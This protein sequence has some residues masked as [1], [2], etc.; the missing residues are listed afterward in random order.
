MFNFKDEGLKFLITMIFIF[1]AAA[2]IVAVAY[3]LKSNP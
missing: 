3:I 1:A 2:T